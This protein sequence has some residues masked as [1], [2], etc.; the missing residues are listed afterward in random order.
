M[1]SGFYIRNS[2]LLCQFILIS[3]FYDM[4]TFSNTGIYRIGSL[5][6]AIILLIL[7]LGFI[8]AIIY[9][10]FSKNIV[11]SRYYDKISPLFSDLK[12]FKKHK[13]HQAVFLIRRLI[14]VILLVAFKFI[15]S[16]IVVIIIGVLNIYK[17][18]L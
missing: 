16:R 10:V 11:N 3:S 2:L 14:Y 18:D 15:S 13:L 17:I 8:V 1:F 9:F 5:V 4:V 7:Y 12:E 6:F